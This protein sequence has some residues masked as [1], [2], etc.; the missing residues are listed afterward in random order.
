MLF[1]IKLNFCYIKN[2]YSISKY[3]I[4]MNSQKYC[5]IC[6][7]NINKVN[8]LIVCNICEFECCKQCF[9]RYI[10]TRGTYLQCM[11]CKSEY[12]RST[13]F[14]Y[15]GKTF[16]N[17]EY[18]TI[19]EDIIYDNEKNALVMTQ[20]KIDRE[21]LNKKIEKDMEMKIDSLYNDIQD[22]ETSISDFKKSDINM[23]VFEVFETIDNYE[24]DINNIKDT[25]RNTRYK[26]RQQLTNND[27]KNIKINYVK[28][29]IN[30]NCS[31][32][33]SEEITTDNNNLI[34]S[35]CSTICCTMC[36]EEL[37]PV[38]ESEHVCDQDVLETLKFIE[39]DSKPCPGCN[40][41]IHKI[42]GCFDKHTIIPLFDGT[43]KLAYEIMAGDKLIGIDNTPRTVLDIIRGVDQLYKVHQ[44]NGSSY[45][46]NSKHKLCLATQHDNKLTMQV[47]EFLKTPPL[48]KQHLYGYRTFNNR[49][50]KSILNIEKHKYGA[51]YGFILD[52]DHKF[53]YVDGTVLS[54]CDQMYCT[55]CHSAFSW[56]TL[57]IEKGRIH[58][59]HYYEYLRQNNNEMNRDPLDIQCGRELDF[60]ITNIILSKIQTLRNK[61]SRQ[62]N[63]KK[64]LYME[65]NIIEKYIR[66]VNHLRSDTLPRYINYVPNTIN[67]K[68]RIKYLKG[69]Y[70]LEEF[71]IKIQRTDKSYQ[72]KLEIIDIINMYTNCVTDIIYR[73]IDCDIDLKKYIILY[74]ELETLET[75]TDSI[76]LSVST[77][78]NST[79]KSLTNL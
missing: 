39:K 12:N 47:D 25:I 67:E 10:T 73:L 57:K 48:Y 40:V 50:I 29:C 35:I 54:N 19:K 16:I 9:K 1:C 61:Q 64:V 36:K 46:V 49:L 72:L 13:I 23:K 65:K 79:N 2:I 60:T 24:N 55:E 21:L 34:C 41:I 56:R 30:H 6:V 53:L 78:Y 45:I 14:K 31:A 26:Y 74:K 15:L 51:Y 76:L 4:S 77:I 71:K 32:L 22:I 37:Q 5:D 68:Y 3:Y 66:I 59:P 17:N 27:S 52:D 70:T 18:K 43:N 33:L 63:I 75:Y 69:E 42:A 11:S 7:E 8:K 58:N 20:S 62:T 44:S 28:K 38:D